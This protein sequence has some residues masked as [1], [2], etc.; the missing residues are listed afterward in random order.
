MCDEEIKNPGKG[1]LM[2]MFFCV[3]SAASAVKSIVQ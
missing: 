3:Q 2:K 1:G